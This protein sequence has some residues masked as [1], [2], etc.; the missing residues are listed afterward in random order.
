MVAYTRLNDSVLAALVRV[1]RPLIGDAV[2]GIL[3]KGFRVTDQLASRI[4]QDPDGIAQRAASLSALDPEDLS[5]L[6]ALLRDTSRH[7]AAAQPLPP[8]P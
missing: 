7:S 8:T 2:T 6:T 4:A 3:V 1:L 5:T